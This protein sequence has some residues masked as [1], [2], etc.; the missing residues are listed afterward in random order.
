MAIATHENRMLSPQEV[1]DLVGVT[2]GSVRRWISDGKLEAVPLG[3][4]PNPHLRVSG[5]ALAGFLGE[6][7]KA[8]DLKFSRLLQDAIADELERSEAMEATLEGPQVYEVAIEDRDNNVYTGRITG[9]LLATSGDTDVY[10]TD[11]GRVIL[12][13]GSG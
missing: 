6:R 1:A 4:G 8:A 10:L 13:D 3:D 11:D 2:E 9:K 7:A 5:S 12:H